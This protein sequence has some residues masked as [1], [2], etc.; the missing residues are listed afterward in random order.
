[1]QENN[2]I[3][4][5]EL[6]I[7][8]KDTF[9]YLLK[10]WILIGIFSGIGAVL[11]ILYSHYSKPSFNSTLSFIVEGEA[12]AGGGLAS[13]ASS[14]GFGGLGG[15]KN[16]MFN[17]DNILE[18]LETR[19]L[20][21]KAL[22]KPIPSDKKKTFLELYIDEN[23]LQEILVK[24]KKKIHFIPNTPADQLTIDQNEIINRIY[25]TLITKHL[26]IEHKNPD[27]S[28][29]YIDMNSSS[30][31]FSGFF[32]GILINVVSEYYIETKTRKAKLN[33]EVIKKQT[34]SVRAE[35]NSSITGVAA[36]NDE[37][38]LLNPA[39]NIK[40]VP[41][42]HKQVN[43]QAN[44]IILG[45][46]VKNLELARMNLLNET[47]FIEIIDRPILPLNKK[48]LSK[49]KGLLYGGIIGTFLIVG[50]L[51]LIQYIKS[52]EKK[53]KEVLPS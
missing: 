5:Q 40:R 53:E 18:L 7:K 28:I 49:F 48:Q 6:Y 34:D 12:G 26:S 44:T 11:G 32:P 13:I 36:A 19:K 42:A 14:F 45:E 25:N 50:I 41:S 21:Q 2:N 39:F 1:M 9:R 3:T 33:Y 35:L 30:E 27:N 37:T 29:I 52:F 8:V 17:S 23:N 38:F 16:N 31:E 20:V 47:P 4:V 24:K 46:L 10:K 15:G 51:L 22:L 43:V